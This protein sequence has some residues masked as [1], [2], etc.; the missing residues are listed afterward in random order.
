MTEV[1]ILVLKV[2]IIASLAMFLGYKTGIFNLKRIPAIIVFLILLALFSAELYS[3]IYTNSISFIAVFRSSFLNFTLDLSFF[4]R[5][6]ILTLLLG[7]I[8]SVFGV[9]PGVK[10]KTVK[11]LCSL[12]VLI[13]IAVV[14]AVYGTV[15]VG[16][17]IKI[18]FKF[19]PVFITAAVF[20]PIWGGTV[21]AL[22]DILA[23]I[24]SPVGGAFLPQ[25]TMIEFMY[26]FTYGLFFFNMN[27]WDGYKSMIKIIICVIF[28]IT[29]L[30]LWMTTKMLTPIMHMSFNNLLVMRAVSGVINMAIQLIVISIMS[31]YISSFRKTLK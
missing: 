18:S 12:G 10:L 14:L 11:D 4:V 27:R 3:S 28:Q 6:F 7:I 5:I 2:L 16:S 31:K 26:G 21:G 9:T 20:G 22:A 24:V 30:N 15:R 23:Y 17:A 8:C 19:I 29:V 1:L 13:A 25:I